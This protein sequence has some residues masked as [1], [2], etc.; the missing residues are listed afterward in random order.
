MW[1]TP[2]MRSFLL[3]TRKLLRS[4]LLRRRHLLS[5]FDIFNVCLYYQVWSSSEEEDS[6]PESEI[7]GDE[8]LPQERLNVEKNG[9][10][11]KGYREH[12]S[13][14]AIFVHRTRN[15]DK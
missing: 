4:S 3:K 1:F 5:L 2:G 11:R 8:M 10:K 13:I 6:E 15:S 12:A 14:S 7:T 9:N